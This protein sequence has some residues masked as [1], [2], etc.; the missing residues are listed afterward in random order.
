VSVSTT[1]EETF[2][3]RNNLKDLN[4]ETIDIESSKI[5][6]A[7]SNFNTNS[8]FKVKFGAI[9]FSTDYLKS[10]DEIN[11]SPKYDLSTERMPQ[12]NLKKDRILNKIYE[13]VR[14]HIMSPHL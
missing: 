13:L 8:E 3:Q 7:V 4:V 12:S 5:A 10:E 14:Q 1:M 2:K 6:Q 11:L 9:H